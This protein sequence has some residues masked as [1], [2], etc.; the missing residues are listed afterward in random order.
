MNVERVPIA[1]LTE[2]SNNARAHPERN[3]KVIEDS[4][5]QFGQQKPIVVS[6]D[7]VVI[8]GNGLLACARNMG[9]ETVLVVR[10]DLEGPA[11]R[12]Y[13]LADNRAGELS[14]WDWESLARELESLQSAGFDLA[15][16]GWDEHDV[17]LVM[18]ADFT[19]NPTDDQPEARAGRLVVAFDL[20]Q[21]AEVRQHLERKG[22][23][24]AAPALI[25]A[26]RAW[27]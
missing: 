6:P 12:A 19:V 20:Q 7:G 2:D 10:T 17:D 5:R 22:L 4:L 11:A 1:D 8:A 24:D 15:S 18:A 21:S 23:T 14:E 16:V 26:L 3:L 27:A 9:W 13:A 25:D